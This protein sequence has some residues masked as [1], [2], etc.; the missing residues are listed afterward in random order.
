MRALVA[1]LLVSCNGSHSTGSPPPDAPRAADAAVDADVCAGRGCAALS[2]QLTVTV[3]DAMT[4]MPIAEQPTFTTP[5]W[6]GPLGFTC[7]A[8]VTPCPSWV[9]APQAALGYDV[10]LDVAA[11]GYLPATTMVKFQMPVDCCGAGPAVAT[12]VTLSR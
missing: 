3:L 12:T 10:Q 1:A 9:L 2:G 8:A 11:P 7:S 5:V 4:Q 6:S